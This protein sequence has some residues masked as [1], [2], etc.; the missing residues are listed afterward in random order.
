MYAHTSPCTS[1]SETA[2]ACALVGATERARASDATATRA[3]RENVAEVHAAAVYYKLSLGEMCY[4]HGACC[5][6]TFVDGY[7][8]RIRF[9]G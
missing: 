6:D 9:W 8:K 5:L 1:A 2:G 4:E 3:A 7:V